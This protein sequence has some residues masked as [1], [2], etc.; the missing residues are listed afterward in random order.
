MEKWSNSGLKPF[1]PAART[2]YRESFN[3]PERIHAMCEDYR[4][5]ATIDRAADEAD[6]KAGKH[7][8]CPTLILWGAFYLTGKDTDPLA[9]WRG[10]LAPQAEG[11]RTSGGHFVAEEDPAGTLAAL[12]AFL[13]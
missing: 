11:A 10:S 8:L 5:G 9:I 12:E 7:I 4:A 13:A 2:A 3:V 6:L 1:H